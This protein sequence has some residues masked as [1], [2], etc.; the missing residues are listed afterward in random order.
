[1]R[2]PADRRAS[3]RI[4]LVVLGLALPGCSSDGANPPPDTISPVDARRDTNKPAGDQSTSR[5]D[6]SVDAKVPGLVTL[7]NAASICSPTLLIPDPGEEG[8]LCAARLTPGPT[9][10]PFTVKTV[11]HR[12]GHGLQKGIDCNAALEHQVHLTVS[13]ETKPEATPASPVVLPIPAA[14]PSTIST[15]EGRWVM[16]DLAQPL[17]LTSGQHLFVSIKFAGTHPKVLC[18]AVNTEGAYQ[19]DRNYW[20][21]AAAAPYKWVTLESLGLTGSIMANV[22]GVVGK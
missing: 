13:S 3:L 1:M 22:V 4:G 14:D 5:C 18:V 8:H 17:T 6:I 2:T 19:A 16:T 7:T 20:S 21:G 9:E 11:R 12:L 10:Y 15:T